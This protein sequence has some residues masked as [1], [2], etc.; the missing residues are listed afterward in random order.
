MLS[1][2]LTTTY[3]PTLM[4]FVRT[5]DV[6]KEVNASISCQS[7]E[8]PSGNDGPIVLGALCG[9]RSLGC[10]PGAALAL[11]RCIEAGLRPVGLPRAPVAALETAL[12]T[13]RTRDAAAF[14]V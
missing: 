12:E 5:D 8:S 1:A 9:D 2:K 7:R 11:F 13:N 3:N 4:Y 10:L 6:R 14:P